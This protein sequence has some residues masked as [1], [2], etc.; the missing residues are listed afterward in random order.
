MANIL[1]VEDSED[2]QEMVVSLLPA[3]RVVIAPGR[4]RAEEELQKG[5]FDLLIIDV[6]L[7]DGNGFELCSRIQSQHHEEIPVIFVTAKSDLSDK[8]LGFSLGADDYITKPIDPIEFRARV[9][10]RIR[11]ALLKTSRGARLVRGDLSIDMLTQKVQ[12]MDGQ[13]TKGTLELT[14]LEFKLLLYFAQ[15]EEEVLTREQL[16]AAVW[17][18]QTH[19]F[20]RTIDTHVSHLRKKLAQTSCSVRSV[21]G[22]GYRFTCNKPATTQSAD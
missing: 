5:R 17:G 20:D 8:V 18:D 7:P 14:Q 2:I 15:H 13:V 10:A 16:L 6:M 9:E 11:K 19:V 12:V 22:A 3:H 1:L 21:Y 4:K